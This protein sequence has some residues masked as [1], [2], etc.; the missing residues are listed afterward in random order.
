MAIKTKDVSAGHWIVFLLAVSILLGGIVRFLPGIQA[1][2]PLNDGGMFLSMV[3]DLRESGYALPIF[4]SY[5]HLQIPYAYPPFGFYVARI[6]SDV[7]RISELDLLRWIPPF[8]NVLSIFAFYRLA[9]ELLGSKLRGALASTFYA[10]TPGA[11]GWFIMGGGL[12]RSFGSLFLLL[13]AL[14][15]L[16]LF[17]RGEEKISGWRRLAAGWQFSATLRRESMPRLWAS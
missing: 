7:F 9:S 17:R 2:F 11:F 13:T 14:F 4:T 8:I 6:L 3:R 16:R 5:N 12:T 10:L 1:G 15:T